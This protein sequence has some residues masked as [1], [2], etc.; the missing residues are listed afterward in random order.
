MSAP[1][2]SSISSRSSSARARPRLISS[3]VGGAVVVRRR[4][5][6]RWRRTALLCFKMWY[7]VSLI[8]ASDFPRRSFQRCLDRAADAFGLRLVARFLLHLNVRSDGLGASSY[9]TRF[10]VF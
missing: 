5:R 3:V 1:T 7:V 4:A 9:R 10:L 8:I 6:G 2:L